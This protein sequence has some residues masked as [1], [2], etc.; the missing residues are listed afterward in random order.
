M[1]IKL[2]GKFL[3]VIITYYWFIVFTFCYS[4]HEGANAKGQTLDKFLGKTYDT[5]F[6]PLFD[7]FLEAA[8]GEFFYIYIIVIINPSA[9]KKTCDSRALLALSPGPSQ[10]ENEE[11]STMGGTTGREK[12]D[13]LSD[14]AKLRNANIEANKVLLASL[15][16]GEGGEGILGE[17][18]KKTKKN[19]KWVPN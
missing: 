13:G 12:N 16:V 11:E 3:P 17:S 8:F 10:T 5:Q 19:K 4:F 1:Q 7:K 14:Y 18:S 15:G 6:L 9:D 2:F